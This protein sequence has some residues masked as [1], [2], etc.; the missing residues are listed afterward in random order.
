MPCLYCCLVLGHE[1][2]IVTG[3]THAACALPD[4]TMSYGIA[5]MSTESFVYKGV[6][7]DIHTYIYSRD[8]VL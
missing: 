1:W 6:Y 8:A 2:G 7:G 3:L 4:V 5:C